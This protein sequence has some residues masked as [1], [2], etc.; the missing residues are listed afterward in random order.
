MQF[1]V[2]GLSV[3]FTDDFYEIKLEI[4]MHVTIP[5]KHDTQNHSVIQLPN[6]QE[7]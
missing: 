5:L 2:L 4:N 3:D 7:T 6:H 1:M